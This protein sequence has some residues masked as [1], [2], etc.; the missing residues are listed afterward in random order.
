MLFTW[1]RSLAL[2][3]AECPEVRARVAA[4]VT[5]LLQRGGIG[6]RREGNVRSPVLKARPDSLFRTWFRG[7]DVW[8]TGGDVAARWIKSAR[9]LHSVIT[10]RQRCDH[11]TNRCFLFFFCCPNFLWPISSRSLHIKMFKT[12]IDNATLFR[13]KKPNLIL[14]LIDKKYLWKI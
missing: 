2:N 13:G 7:T 5:G 4:A 8:V 6:G 10:V 9:F 14:H 1:W 3:G 11:S 12:Q